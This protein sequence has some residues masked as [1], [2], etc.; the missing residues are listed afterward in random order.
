MKI[1]IVGTGRVGSTLAYTLVLRGLADELVL[2]S[3]R[4]S[5]A[6]G[7][8]ADLRHALAFT[9]HAMRI[10][11]GE[12]A[13]TADSDLIV[14]CASVPWPTGERN[15]A[16]LAVGNARLFS[17]LVPSLAAAS[18]NTILLVVSNP[19]DALTWHTWRLSG[20]PPARV[21]GTGTLVDSA[22]YRALLSREL[23]IHP[24][25]L[26]AYVLGEHGPTQFPALS[27]AQTGGEPI[28]DDAAHRRLFDDAV[29]DG[30]L[31]FE[32]KG[33]TSFAI[34]MGA[35][36]IIQ[37]IARDTR[38]TL[39]VSTRIN[40]WLG[41]RDVCLSVPVVIGRAGVLR[42]LEPPLS[43]AEASAFRDSAQAVRA[44]VSEMSAELARERDPR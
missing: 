25:D 37:A 8:A 11:G 14:L 34:S 13:D 33:Y 38:R 30:K 7:E 28:R 42:V 9:E 44:T 16:A 29:A 17:E 40:G 20:L 19:V 12:I 31:V 39:P 21:I 24:D 26:R 10:G 5:I 6:A 41:V 27:L 15:R 22:R 3:R 23:G 36:L 18:P 4:P 35:T 2:A 32:A 1:S 43:E